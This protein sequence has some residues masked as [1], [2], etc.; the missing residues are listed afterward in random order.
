[1]EKI[2]LATDLDRTVLPNGGQPESPSARPLL[3]T[4][5]ARP[6]V[7]LVY[8]SGRG[9]RLQQ[10]A[11][12]EYKIPLPDYAIGDVGTSIYEVG[13][14]ATWKSVSAWEQKIAPDWQG[15]SWHYIN[16][17]FDDMPE[18]RL[19]DDAPDQQNTFKVSYFTAEDID[20]DALLATMRERTDREGLQVSLIWSIDEA[21][22]TG[23]LDVLPLSAT[24]LHA[25]QFI[26]QHLKFSE[27]QTVF[28]GDSG[29]DIP[30]LVSGLQAVMVKN[31]R[32]EVQDEVM[33][34][35]NEKDITNRIYTAQGDFLGMNGNYSAGVLE[36][37][38]HFFPVIETL[39]KQ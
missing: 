17:L 33:S 11:I 3:R 39:L 34:L 32:Q 37:A 5:A 29:N 24:K 4:L 2:L 25:L 13:Q 1:M 21:R 38:A 28:C 14:Q 36:G 16:E 27:E 6:E 26:R 30:A 10:D 7:T 8:V 19:Q 15:K 23:L 35:T 31:T 18:L 20:R 22:H 9:Q 12:A